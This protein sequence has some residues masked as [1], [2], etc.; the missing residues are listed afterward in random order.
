MNIAYTEADKRARATSYSSQNC[1]IS[2]N[3]SKYAGVRGSEQHPCDQRGPPVSNGLSFEYCQ[4]QGRQNRIA[5]STHNS[6]KNSLA[7]GF[8][9]SVPQVVPTENSLTEPMRSSV[10][11]VLQKNEA[12]NRLSQ[13]Q[14]PLGP[15]E[16]IP[17][18]HNF[19]ADP[20]LQKIQ[21][22]RQELTISPENAPNGKEN[23]P[24][25]NG[26]KK[27]AQTSGSRGKN[28]SGKWKK[29]KGSKPN[30]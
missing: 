20:S 9:I 6:A 3:D 30:P 28:S 27:G 23:S 18:T 25:A 24:I 12:I 10:A 7:S 17:F 13:H 16:N 15:I 1:Y 26:K 22:M 8:E 2:S 4:N 29:N 5:S 21:P 19:L 14:T 11:E